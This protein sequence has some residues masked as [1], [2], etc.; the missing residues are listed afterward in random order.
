M[1]KKADMLWEEVLE[2]EESGE[3]KKPSIY[4]AKLPVWNPTMRPLGK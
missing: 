3:R 1:A 4:V 2:L